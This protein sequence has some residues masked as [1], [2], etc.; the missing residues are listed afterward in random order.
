MWK[1]CLGIAVAAAL[2]WCGCRQGGNERRVA[3]LLSQQQDDGQEIAQMSKR[4]DRIDERVAGIEKNITALLGGGAGEEPKLKVASDFA[5]TAEYKSIMEDIGVLGEQVADLQGQFVAFRDQ[6][7]D[8]RQRE[9]SQ[10]DPRR[11]MRA[12]GDPQEMGQRLDQLVKNASGRIQDPGARDQFSAEVNELK[13]KYA[14]SLSAEEKREQA[15]ALLSEQL[16]TMTDER[17]RTRLEEQL[18]SLDEASGEDLDRRVD[19]MLQFQRMREIGELTERYNI[20]SE[21]V[22][23]SGLMTFGGRGAPGGGF[24]PG[25]RGR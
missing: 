21:V 4:V 20:P 24:G 2:L 22:R 16:S 7:R 23:D 10:Q 25:R 12:M 13:K 9:G 18:R 19:F 15:R 11:A 5:T 8:A 3:D 1:K 14:A 6:Q 17:G